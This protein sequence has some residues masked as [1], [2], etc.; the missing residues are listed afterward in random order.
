MVNKQDA[1]KCETCGCELGPTLTE[2]YALQSMKATR[3]ANI[4]S[5]L[6]QEANK[7]GKLIGRYHDGDAE[8]AAS[9]EAAFRVEQEERRNRDAIGLVGVP[10]IYKCPHCA[11]PVNIDQINCG[12]FICGCE[13]SRDR[14]ASTQ[15]PQHDERN[16]MEKVQRGVVRGCGRQFTLDQST[17][18][19]V[20]CTGR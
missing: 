4:A 8:L 3:A 1:K 13:I 9:L 14:N 6:R 20:P 5:S 18:T 15:L 19:L 7:I 17:N 2:Q 11:I 10:R 16:A 12:I